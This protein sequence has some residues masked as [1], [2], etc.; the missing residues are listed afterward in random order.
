MAM[1]AI[2][3][4]DMDRY[5]DILRGDSGEL[6]LL[7]KD[8]LINVTSFFRDP[9]VFDFLAENIVPDLVR[10]H[11]PDQPAAH[12]DRRMQH[13]RGDL[14]ACHPLPRGDHGGASSTSSC[15]SSPPMLTRMR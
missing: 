3:T 5:L 8:L 10:S 7:A 9:Q 11:S 15:R 1:A 13:R 14:L 2:K 4:D 12:L 6:D